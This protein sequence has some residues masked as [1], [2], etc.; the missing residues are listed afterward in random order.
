[1][2]DVLTDDQRSADKFTSTPGGA[3]GNQ[4]FTTCYTCST[5]NQQCDGVKPTCSP[6]DASGGTCEWDAPKAAEIESSTAGML[7]EQNPMFTTEGTKRTADAQSKETNSPEPSSPSDP[8]NS[9]KN[10][11]SYYQGP[12][13]E[14][15]HVVWLDGKVV[16]LVCYECGANTTPDCN[17]FK[18]AVGYARHVRGHGKKVAKSDHEVFAKALQHGLRELSEAELERLLAGDKSIIRPNLRSK[19]SGTKKADQDSTYGTAQHPIDI[20]S[21]ANITARPCFML[22]LRHRGSRKRQT[23]GDNSEVPTGSTTPPASAYAP[24]NAPVVPSM[25]STL[26]AEALREAELR[27]EQ[28]KRIKVENFDDE[29]RNGMLIDGEESSGILVDDGDRGGMLVDGEDDEFLP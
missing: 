9:V 1:M 19:V 27:G 29:D 18:G 15:R 13:M 6:C 20:D 10:I 8:V 14:Y 17:Y 28:N 4:S 7:R 3:V 5:L 2:R 16:E 22:N 24:P 23:S 12:M 11:E 25:I 26:A 21:D